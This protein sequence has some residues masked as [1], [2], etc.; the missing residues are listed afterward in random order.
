M[1]FEVRVIVWETKEV[2]CKDVATSCNDLF[3]RGTIGNQ[4][5]ETD[6]H[7]RCRVKGSFNWR[8]KYKMQLPLDPDEDF[9]KN[10]LNVSLWDRDIITSNEMICETQIDLND[11]D[12][13]K[14]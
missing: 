9:G 10:I 3:V 5:L 6:T 14:K 8:W 1:D 12:I 2:K 4:V 11:H 13:L 7:W